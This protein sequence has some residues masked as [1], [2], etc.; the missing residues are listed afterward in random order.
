[1]LF[2]CLQTN[3]AKCRACDSASVGWRFVT[4]LPLVRLVGPD[5]AGLHEQPAIDAAV[6]EPLR[7][8]GQLAG[9]QQPDVLLPL[10]E[11]VEGVRLVVRGDDALDEP[12]RLRVHDGAGGVGIDRL[13]EREDAAEG[14]Q[15][16]AVPGGV[17]GV[18]EL[19]RPSP[20]RTGCCA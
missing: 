9:L 17:E 12:L 8:A 4:H 16:V 13:V 2:T 15:R 7:T 18:G 6:V 14:G 3:Q 5:V 10:L 20:R 19:A 1:M 11:G